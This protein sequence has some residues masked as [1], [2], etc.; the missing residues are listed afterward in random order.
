M[1]IVTSSQ[2]PYQSLQT[3]TWVKLICG[4]SYQDM[5]TVRRLVMIYALAGVDCVDIAADPA[6]VLAAR[7]GLGDAAALAPYLYRDCQDLRAGL[8]WLMVSLN[9]SED[10]HFRKAE[11]DPKKCPVSCDRPCE[12]VCPTTA[13]QFEGIGEGGVI[14]DLCYGCGRCLPICPVNNITAQYR[15]ARPEDFGDDWLHLIDAVEIHTQTGR[16]REFAALWQRL[17]AWMPTLKLVSISCPDHDQV[18]PY[19][20]DL[21]QIMAPLAVPLIWQTDGR[22]MSGD[23]GRGTTHATIRLARKVLG[24]GLPGYVQAAGGTNSYT[25][26]KLRELGLVHHHSN[27]AGPSANG[28]TPAETTGRIAGIAYGSYARA[29][30]MPLLGAIDADVQTW[31]ATVEASQSLA[32][33]TSPSVPVSRADGQSFDKSNLSRSCSWIEPKLLAIDRQSALMQALGLA[34]DLVRLLKDGG[35]A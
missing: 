14:H 33:A 18:V 15:Q 12:A 22:P 7:Q 16:Q 34:R 8:P 9:D 3:G 28:Q 13:I 1:V 26:D 10:P 2:L 25:V 23:L 21:H 32:I 29:L 20:W 17:T 5:P 11:F 24:A 30:V 4:A 6:V 19:L 31:L 35:A 27:H